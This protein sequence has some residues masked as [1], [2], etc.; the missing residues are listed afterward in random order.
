MK[1]LNVGN[2]GDIKLN[3]KERSTDL[4]YRKLKISKKKK[5]KEICQNINS[6]PLDN[7]IGVVHLCNFFFITLYVL[8]L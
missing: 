2:D 4:N 3:E 1:F 7:G 5:W 8:L 6:L